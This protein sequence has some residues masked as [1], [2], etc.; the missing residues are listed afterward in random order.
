[1]FLRARRERLKPADVNLPAGVRRRARGLRREEVA[2]LAGISATYYVF[3]EQGR[4]VKPSRPVLRFAPAEREYLHR[5]ASD[6][7]E[8][9]P[10]VAPETLE[11]AI[12]AL[13]SRLDPLPAYITGR[14]WN[15]LA[16][17]RAARLL[18]TDWTQ[19]AP[20]ERNMVWWTFTNPAAREIFVEWEAEA[21]AL[22]GRFR[23]AAAQAPDNL[24]FHDLVERLL[25]ASPE[26]RAWWP[27]YDVTSLSSGDKRLRHPKLGELRLQHTVLR[28]V[29]NSDCKIVVFNASEDDQRRLQKMIRHKNA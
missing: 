19:L 4:D 11:T 27:R 21:S 2:L 15:V 13:V 5:L 7:P 16:A 25:I 3:L 14:T 18:W 24:E 26:M 23:A 10:I 17:D 8:P 29:E 22:L 1:M 12:A 6:Q 20:E 9:K 28:T